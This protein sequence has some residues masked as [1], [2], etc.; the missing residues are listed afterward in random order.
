M[1]NLMIDLE[2]LGTKPNAP[3]IA[4]GAVFFDP[5][6]G[7][8]GNEFSATINP[9]SAQEFRTAD[10][11]TLKWWAK[12]SQEAKDR[13]F[14]GVSSMTDALNYFREFVKTTKNVKPWG[15][16][17]TFDISMLEDCFDQYGIK[18]PWQFWNVRDVRTVVDIGE[19][20]G[21]MRDDVPFE[22]VPHVALDDAKHQAKYVSYMI[23]NLQLKERE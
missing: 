5:K 20:V 13:S 6:T 23:S 10:E 17:A 16:G 19:M 12:Q 3:I 18:T 4:I 15:N 22:G 14:C 9:E 1:N 2:T 8:L 11:N 7:K 21:L